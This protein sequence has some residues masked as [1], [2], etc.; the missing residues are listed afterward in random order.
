MARL[1]S[2]AATVEQMQQ[3]KNRHVVLMEGSF[4]GKLA[5]ANPRT[6]LI[7]LPIPD[8]KTVLRWVGCGDSKFSRWAVY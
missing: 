1:I 5:I 6:Y 3:V 2:E 4:V 7:T 8:R